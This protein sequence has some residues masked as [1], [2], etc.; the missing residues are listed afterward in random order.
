M[1]EFADVV[2]KYS[3]LEFYLTEYSVDENGN[4]TDDRK[5]SPA[6]EEPEGD[7]DDGNADNIATGT[8]TTFPSR[9]KLEQCC[10]VGSQK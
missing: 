6:Y 2:D 7:S 8:I 4:F 3:S 5:D 1:P 9:R 10:K